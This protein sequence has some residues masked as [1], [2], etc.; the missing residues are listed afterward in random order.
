MG[1]KLIANLVRKNANSTFSI[2]HLVNV[3]KILFC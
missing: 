1:N 2:Y 3:S